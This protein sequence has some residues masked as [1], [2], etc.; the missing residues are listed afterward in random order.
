MRVHV[1]YLRDL[2]LPVAR[3]SVRTRRGIRLHS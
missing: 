1:L 2:L 3:G